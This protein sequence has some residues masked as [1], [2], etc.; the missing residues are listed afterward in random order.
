MGVVYLFG[1]THNWKYPYSSTKNLQ[2]FRICIL[3]IRK[4][5]KNHHLGRSAAQAATGAHGG[6]VGIGFP[7]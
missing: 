1:H 7:N 2:R 3:D 5:N 4:F 6:G